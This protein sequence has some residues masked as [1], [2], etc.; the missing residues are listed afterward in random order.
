MKLFEYS[1]NRKLWR[2]GSVTGSLALAALVP[3]PCA[4]ASEYIR[5]QLV[6]FKHI[7][8]NILYFISAVTENP[9]YFTEIPQFRMTEKLNGKHKCLNMLLALKISSSSK[10][11]VAAQTKEEEKSEKN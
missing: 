9:V 7:I 8:S 5:R 6:Y 2:S 4:R 1:L 3:I 11:N 10:F